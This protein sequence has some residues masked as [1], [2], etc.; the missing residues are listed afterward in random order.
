MLDGWIRNVA[1]KMTRHFAIAETLDR[2]FI[3]QRPQQWLQKLGLPLRALGGERLEYV[4][5]LASLKKADVPT[6]R[7]RD[8]VCVRSAVFDGLKRRVAR[9]ERQWQF[10]GGVDFSNGL[11]PCTVEDRTVE[12]VIDV[13]AHSSEGSVGLKHGSGI[14]LG[15]VDR[16]SAHGSTGSIGSVRC[17]ASGITST[18][19]REQ[20]GLQGG[21]T[22]EGHVRWAWSP[23]RPTSPHASLHCGNGATDASA[24]GALATVVALDASAMGASVLH[25]STTYVSTME[26]SAMDASVVDPSALGASGLDASVV[27][28]PTMD[29]SALDALVVT[30][31]VQA[32]IGSGRPPEHVVHV[33]PQLHLFCQG[34][35]GRVEFLEANQVFIGTRLGS[36]ANGPRETLRLFPVSIHADE[37]EKLAQI[38]SMIEDG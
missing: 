18:Q 30:A 28:A 33:A 8:S 22:H 27:N 21:W 23:Q 31:S 16:G 26:A 24:L 5:A 13:P 11:E 17:P 2:D 32:A 14:V 36:H 35:C 7:K 29:A 19:F 4:L 20:H 9:L 12:Q 34:D 6:G 38:S 1:T 25:A 3:A 10:F 15:G 37:A